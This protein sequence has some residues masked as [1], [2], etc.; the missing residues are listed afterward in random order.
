M[1]EPADLSPWVHPKSQAWFRALF[2]RTNLIMALEDEINKPDDQLSPEVARLI[3]AISILLGRPEIWPEDDQPTLKK[4]MRRAKEL[5]QKPPTSGTGKPLSLAEHQA[6]KNSDTQMTH[7]LEILRR[8]LGVS[9][10]KTKLGAPPSWEPF[11][12]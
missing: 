6:H 9:V 5:S 8:R 7:E 10:R 4:I 1:S 12:E 3:L 11:W 2:R